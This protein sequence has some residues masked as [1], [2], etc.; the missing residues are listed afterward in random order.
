MDIM[1]TLVGRKNKLK[2]SF[3]D[4]LGDKGFTLCGYF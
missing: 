4:L 2:N 3:G 1:P